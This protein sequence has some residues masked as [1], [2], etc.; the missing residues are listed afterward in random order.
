MISSRD[1]LIY[2]SIQNNGNWQ[3]IFNVIEA[4]KSGFD[5]AEIEKTIELMPC[6]ALTI[7]DEAYPEWLKSTYKPP[8]VLFYYGDISLISD[9]RKCLSVI[10]SRN[11]SAY[12]QHM[13]NKIIKELNNEFIIV[14]GMARG[15]DS[16]AQ[17]AAIKNGGKTV[18]VLG[19]GIDY[20]YP[21]C[22]IDIYNE[23]KKNHLVIS[24]HYGSMEPNHL[25]FPIRN[26]IIVS[27]SKGLL[28]GEAYPKSGSLSSIT[29]ALNENREVMC[30]PYPGNVDSECN[31]M[32]K[33]GAALVE[34]GKD[35]LNII[36]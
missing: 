1:I 9:Y 21:K 30:V 26:R 27:L 16:V 12:G 29:W 20:V 19:S 5:N 4:R 18:A 23:C 33:E 31:R 7:L 3:E 17:R 8:F 15:I 13:V 24:E 10:G 36:G 32:I 28:V 2:I 6:K 34:S 11:C 14:S 22:N 25:D 35:V